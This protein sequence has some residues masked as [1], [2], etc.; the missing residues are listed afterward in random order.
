MPDDGLRAC[1]V[2]FLKSSSVAMDNIK[3][4]FNN[5]CRLTISDRAKSSVTV[6]IKKPRTSRLSRCLMYR[7]VPALPSDSS[8]LL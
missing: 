5:A 4:G 8:S 3:K 2:S 1:V 7:A 6:L